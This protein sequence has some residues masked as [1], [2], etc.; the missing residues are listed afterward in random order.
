MMSVN[1]A[2]ELDEKFETVSGMV[3]DKRALGNDSFEKAANGN[4][5]DKVQLDTYF[6]DERVRIPEKVSA[7]IDEIIIS[8]IFSLILNSFR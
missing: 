1:Q 6:A 4:G 5:A 3:S 7:S 8:N 2:F